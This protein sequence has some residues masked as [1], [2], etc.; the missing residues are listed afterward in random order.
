MH[1]HARA[2]D[3]RRLQAGR[4]VFGELAGGA[5]LGRLNALVVDAGHLVAGGGQGTVRLR[6]DALVA[7]LYDG[8]DAL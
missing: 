3:A 7:G 5:C 6:V 2:V 4:G 1:G 8:V